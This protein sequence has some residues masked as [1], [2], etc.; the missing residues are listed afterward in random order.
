MDYILLLI[1]ENLFKYIQ[2]ILLSVNTAYD[3]S[4]IKFTDIQN[5][6]LS[7]IIDEI[8]K[9]KEYYNNIRTIIIQSKY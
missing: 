9:L 8:E 2:R 3:Y 4:T 7:I 5:N 6:K 1:N